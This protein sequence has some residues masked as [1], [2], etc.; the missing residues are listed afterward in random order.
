MPRLLWLICYLLAV[1]SPQGTPGTPTVNKANAP[2]II[3]KQGIVFIYGGDASPCAEHQDVRPLP[4]G[5]GFILVVPTQARQENS[6]EVTGIRFLITAEHVI[7][8]R[9]SV[10]IRYNTSSGTT[11][12]CHSLGLEGEG[13]PLQVRD[14]VDLSAIYVPGD[15]AD[16]HPYVFTK[17]DVADQE[18][19]NA[20]HIKEGS[21]VYAVGYLLGA[22]GDALNL[23]ISRFG[24]IDRLSNDLWYKAPPPRP[25]QLEKG[26]IIEINGVPG[27]SGSPVLLREVQL[28]LSEDGSAQ[29]L[30]ASPTIIGVVK[31]T[32]SSGLGPEGVAVI[33]PSDSLSELISTIYSYLRSHNVS[34][35]E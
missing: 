27:L 32:L 6:T 7:H 1:S 14:I 13:T 33:E 26:W 18:K 11:F 22:P 35:V 8:G 21:Q 4:I 31:G 34:I 25:E 16:F 30:A 15:L 19:M 5:T 29:F 10:V 17:R 28:I 3:R 12:G 20:E 24:T 9:S 2:D 23:P